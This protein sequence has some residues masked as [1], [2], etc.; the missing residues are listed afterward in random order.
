MDALVDDGFVVLGGH[1]RPRPVEET[2][3]VVDSV[4]AW[5]IRLD[6]SPLEGDARIR[7]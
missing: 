3:R 1:A 5:T 7:S 2:H 4:E 6:R